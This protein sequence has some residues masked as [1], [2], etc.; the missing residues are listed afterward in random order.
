LHDVLDHVG[1][2]IELV[3]A[4]GDVRRDELPNAPQ[5]RVAGPSAFGSSP[6]SKV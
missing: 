2:G 3:F 6:I 1:L 5:G 4:L